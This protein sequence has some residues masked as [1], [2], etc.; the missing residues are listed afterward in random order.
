MDGSINFASRSDRTIS[1]LT[2]RFIVVNLIL[3]L[4]KK[5]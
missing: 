4:L 1:V 3:K 5:E 2:H